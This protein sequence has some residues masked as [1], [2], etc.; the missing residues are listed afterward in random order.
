MLGVAWLAVVVSWSVDFWQEV[1]IKEI[2][3]LNFIIFILSLLFYFLKDKELSTNEKG[4]CG[5]ILGL[6]K[7]LYL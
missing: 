5:F 4:F 6:E 1:R 3:R 7:L 2:R